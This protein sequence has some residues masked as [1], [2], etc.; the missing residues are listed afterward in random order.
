MFL[1][2]N[3]PAILWSLLIM[4]LCLLPGDK[5]PKDPIVNADKIYHAGAFAL[6]GFLFAYGFTKQSK[7]P[8]VSRHAGKMAFGISAAL[9]GLIELLQYYFVRN[10]QGDWLDFLFDSVGAW[11]G[12]TILLLI[13]RYIS[14][15]N[16]GLNR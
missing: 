7:F 1:K 9:G 13:C 10:R 6:M 4:V 16:K 8:F 12:V 14:N 11:V 5:M 2:Y 15:K 3:I